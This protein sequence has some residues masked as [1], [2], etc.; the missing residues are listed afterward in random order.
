MYMFMFSCFYAKVQVA[1]IVFLHFCVMQKVQLT[2]IF[3]ID[4][5]DFYYIYYNMKENVGKNVFS[6]FVVNAISV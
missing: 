6:L 5:V 4:A 2:N 1:F 3:S